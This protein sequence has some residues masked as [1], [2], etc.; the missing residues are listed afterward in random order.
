MKMMGLIHHIDP[1]ANEVHD[2]DFHG[3]NYSKNFELMESMSN[4]LSRSGWLDSQ[5]SN[6]RSLGDRLKPVYLPYTQWANIV[7]ECRDKIF[8]AKFSGYTP[9][10]SVPSG[11]ANGGVNNSSQPANQLVRILSA[12]YLRKDFRAE[13]EE[14][15]RVIEATILKFSLNKEQERAF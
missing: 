3:K 10:S 1:E 6:V 12:D 5:I 11:D 9:P 4:V 13:K 2:H 7:K 14:S 8:K 15:N